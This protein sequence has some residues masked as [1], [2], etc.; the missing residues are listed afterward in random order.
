MREGGRDGVVGWGVKQGAS[1]GREGG[2]K[3]VVGRGGMERGKVI[4]EAEGER[5]GKEG[6]IR[7]REE[8]GKDMH[9][10]MNIY[11]YKHGRRSEPY[12]N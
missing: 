6:E 10:G 4:N 9:M 5:G 7:R 1:G 2:K 8:E 11:L 3:G 12:V